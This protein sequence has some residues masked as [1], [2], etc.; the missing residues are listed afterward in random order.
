MKK[1]FDSNFW[2][3]IACCTLVG[4]FWLW[5]I[6]RLPIELSMKMVGVEK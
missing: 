6:W 3:L 5:L 4:T 1:V 2:W